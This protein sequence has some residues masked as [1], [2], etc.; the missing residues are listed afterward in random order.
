MTTI[1]FPDQ[2]NTVHDIIDALGR[3]VDFYVP[4]YT[5]CSACSL[6]PVNLSSTDPFCATCEGL[7]YIPTYEEVPVTGYV[8]WGFSEHLGWVAGGQ[9]GEGDCRLQ[10]KYTAVMDTLIDN[11]EYMFVDTKKMKIRKKTLRGTPVINRILLD[12]QELE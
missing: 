8:S 6:D 2:T 12:L 3:Q 7:Y 9:L 11:V 4:S 5:T 1:I 10:L